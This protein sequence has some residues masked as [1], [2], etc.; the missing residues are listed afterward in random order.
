MT[1]ID[2]MRMSP[3]ERL[4]LIARLWD[5]LESDELPMTPAQEAEIDRRLGEADADL[6]A[7]VPWDTLRA[8]L[9][10]RYK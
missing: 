3:R 7:C 10:N 9:S 6:S 2:I 1:M 4:E 5:S 8:E